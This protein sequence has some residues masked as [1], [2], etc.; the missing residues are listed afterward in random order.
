MNDADTEIL[1]RLLRIADLI[2]QD[3]AATFSGTGLNPA[4]V[5][6]LWELHQRGPSTQQTLAKALAVTPAYVTG[7]VDALETHGFAERR[8]HPP[9]AAPPSSH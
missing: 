7:L 5:H 3:M 8:R 2:Q 1:D 6:L 4:R 9:T